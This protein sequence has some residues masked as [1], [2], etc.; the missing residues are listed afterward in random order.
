GLTEARLDRGA[1]PTLAV[2]GGQDD[3]DQAVSLVDPRGQ[4]VPDER[5]RST[6]R[7]IIGIPPNL[8]YR[9][10]RMKVVIL[11]GGF[12]TRLSEGAQLKPKPMIEI[13]GSPILWHIMKGYAR[14]GFTEFVI[15]LGYKGEL[16]KDY[17][18]NYPLINSDLTV[19]TGTGEVSRRKSPTDDWIVH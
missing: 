12:G 3:R 6:E 19:R 1:Q 8:L 17:F 13:G 7:L 15:A 18:L 2:V 4:K 10:S 11:A 5:R 16:I 9:G 14:W